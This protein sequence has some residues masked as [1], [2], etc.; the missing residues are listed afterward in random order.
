MRTVIVFL[1]FIPFG[2]QSQTLNDKNL[3]LGN[4]FISHYKRDFLNSSFGNYVVLQDKEGVIYVGNVFKGIIEFDG[5][6][7]RRV[8]RNGI[9]YKAV[10]DCILANADKSATEIK[11][12]LVVLGSD[13]LAGQ[14]TPD[15]ITMIVIK[16][17]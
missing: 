15:D 4:F 14:T 1:L 17:D 10:E 7:V 9:G 3:E 8:L 13:W 2:L 12:A 5:Q 16:H 11:D 6:R